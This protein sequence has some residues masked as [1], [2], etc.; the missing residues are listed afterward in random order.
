[1]H[2][3]KNQKI[4]KLLLI[5]QQMFEIFTTVFTSGASQ[6]PGARQNHW[7]FKPPAI[8]SLYY[9]RAFLSATLSCFVVYQTDM[10]N[11]KPC[12]ITWNNRWKKLTLDYRVTNIIPNTHSQQ[13]SSADTNTLN[14]FH[15]QFITADVKFSKTEV[16]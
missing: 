3:K 14:Y 10:K 5:I 2:N 13:F 11:D 1:M 12:K 4:I 15:F 9:N 16:I 7:P 8:F 6:P